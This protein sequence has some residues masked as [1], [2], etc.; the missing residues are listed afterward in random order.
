MIETS[1]NQRTHF[2]NAHAIALAGKIRRPFEEI[3]EPQAATV[4]PI[5]GGFGSA[6][7]ENFRFRDIVSFKCAH[8]LVTGSQSTK[9]SSFA[10]L[11]SV[12][13]E[14]LNILDVVTAKKIVARV[15]SRHPVA[16]GD[17]P[18]PEP[19]IIPLGSQFEGLRIAGCELD[20]ELNIDAFSKWETYQSFRKENARLP[21]S[22]GMTVCSLVK[23]VVKKSSCPGLEISGDTIAL[24]QFGKIRLGQF[25]LTSNSR[26]LAMLQVEL[27]CPVGGSAA[28]GVVEGNGSTYP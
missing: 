24:S 26:R 25:L 18:S 1:A 17:E 23:N 27:G 2:Y 15:S 6:R 11:A 28:A 22:R 5:N 14:D 8:A 7:V 12:M 21:E 13:I 19:S 3:I 16:K 20:V 4:L 10:T 9:D